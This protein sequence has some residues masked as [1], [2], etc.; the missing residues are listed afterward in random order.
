VCIMHGIRLGQRVQGAMAYAQDA[1]RMGC[2]LRPGCRA[3]WHTQR[4][5]WEVHQSDLYASSAVL[6]TLPSFFRASL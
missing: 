1:I 2:R 5:C 6:Y 4:A 3:A